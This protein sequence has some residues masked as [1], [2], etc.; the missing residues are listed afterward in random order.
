MS[1]NARS[2]GNRVATAIKSN[3]SPFYIADVCLEDDGQDVIAAAE[4]VRKTL[5]KLQS[6]FMLISAGVKNLIVVVDI[7]A[8]KVADIQ[9]KSWLLASLTGISTTI[10][11]DSTD[12]KATAIIEIDTP[13]KLKDIVRSAAF[14]HLRKYNQLEEE[15]E[16]EEFF[17][18][19]D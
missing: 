3:K 14:A 9:A 10:S 13:F 1:K 4:S 17:G 16:E 18:L 5:G 7:P 6:G 2:E 11:D 12:Q 8:E 15:S 19:D